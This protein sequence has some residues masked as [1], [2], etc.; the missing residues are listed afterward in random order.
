MIG[1][2]TAWLHPKGASVE[3]AIRN[4][5]KAGFKA[6]ELGAWG[7][8]PPA[9]TLVSLARELH[10]EY[11]SVHNIAYRQG[12]PRNEAFGD[13]LSSDDRLVRR[14]AV[15]STL[16]SIELASAV[17]ARFVIIHA[18]QVP[19]PDAHDKQKEIQQLV[20]AGKAARARALTHE[21]MLE[22]SIVAPAAVEAAAASLA[23]VFRRSANFPL[24]LE[25]RAL[26]H[27]IPQPGELA[28]LATVLPERPLFY[29]HDVGHARRL[30]LL[31]LA[32]GLIWLRTFSQ[33]LAGVHLHDAQHF[34]DHRVP[35]AGDIDFK[36]IAPYL[37]RKILR[38]MEL[39]PEPT[40][41][42]LKKGRAHLEACGIA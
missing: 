39:P 40:P 8:M 17:G 22:R 25:C 32:P 3:D 24:A 41:A 42:E 6:I 29:W 11:T 37:S 4:A 14:R 34:R 16:K 36:A 27:E 2:S 10:L 19:V 5:A 20:V 28:F 1:L 13:G 15:D 18:G 26:Y 30:E 23:E 21:C 31:G 38:I 12:L 7:D 35:G 9:K 33:I